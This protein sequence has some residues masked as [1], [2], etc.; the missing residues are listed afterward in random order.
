MTTPSAPTNL[1]VNYYAATSYNLSWDEPKD[2]ENNSQY[3]VYRDD[4]KLF[5]MPP[6]TPPSI[7]LLDLQPG[8]TSISY[9]TQMNPQGVESL[10][11]NKVSITT[12]G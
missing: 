11:S 4:K 2:F 1:H 3:I 7:T 6:G 9:V 12:L 10:P 5:A 8:Q